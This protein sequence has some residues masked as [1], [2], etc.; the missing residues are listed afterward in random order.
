MVI[1][2]NSCTTLI[3]HCVVIVE[4]K[5]DLHHGVKIGVCHTIVDHQTTDN[6][7]GVFC[8]VDVDIASAG[9]MIKTCGLRWRL[10]ELLLAL[11]SKK[12]TDLNIYPES[13]A[14]GCP[15]K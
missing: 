13:K 10:G 7:A 11:L 14:A 9:T 15:R 8:T 2:L 6:C 3:K 12:K 4:Y 1:P 5:D